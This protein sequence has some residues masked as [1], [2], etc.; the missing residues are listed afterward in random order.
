MSLLLLPFYYLTAA[1][2]DRDVVLGTLLE[3]H[4]SFHRTVASP[5]QVEEA[6]D[7]SVAGCR[8][9]RGVQAS[10]FPLKRMGEEVSSWPRSVVELQVTM[11]SS[12]V[13]TVTER[14]F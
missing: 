5:S 10:P 6:G 9:L 14:V 4:S 7:A 12:L 8:P 13:P 2:R 1:F 11:G 3:L